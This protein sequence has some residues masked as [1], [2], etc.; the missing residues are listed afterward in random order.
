MASRRAGAL[1]RLTQAASLIFPIVQQCVDYDAVICKSFAGM[2]CFPVLVRMANPDLTKDKNAERAVAA[3]KEIS[4]EMQKQRERSERRA[5]REAK[6]GR[7]ADKARR[8]Q[9][10]RM[11]T[12][13]E[14]RRQSATAQL[15]S[16]DVNAKQ[17]LSDCAHGAVFEVATMHEGG[18]ECEIADESD[19]PCSS[20]SSSDEDAQPGSRVAC[21][22]PQLD[23]HAEDVNETNNRHPPSVSSASPASLAGSADTCRR[24][25]SIGS[26]SRN[27][28]RARSLHGT[29]CTQP[30]G[31][32]QA[33][34]SETFQLPT[35]V[36]QLHVAPRTGYP[37]RLPGV[38]RPVPLPLRGPPAP[39]GPTRHSRT[40]PRS[41]G[42]VN[43]AP[44]RFRGSSEDELAGVQAL[45]RSVSVD[46][47]QSK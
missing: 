44:H 11:I 9:R 12:A 38:S 36:L 37:P 47:T 25:R 21:K 31:Q 43:S 20:D 32:Q 23:A 5:R 2:A 35:L 10:D 27:K 19:G 18:Y 33:V 42:L 17:T 7:A 13:R 40:Q 26:C 8:K 41:P 15:E 4:D 16:S 28:A 24:G 22:R 6:R 39:S 30:K 34:R 29:S 14:K 1:D 45:R 46:G 3:F